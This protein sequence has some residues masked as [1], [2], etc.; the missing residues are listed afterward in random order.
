MI[1]RQRQINASATPFS[2]AQRYLP[3]EL[4]QGIRMDYGLGKLSRVRKRKLESI[5]EEDDD[6]EDEEEEEEEEEEAEEVEL[7]TE[8][9]V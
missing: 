3:R 8:V 7:E 4:L 6:E 9:E 2:L 1:Y 5:R